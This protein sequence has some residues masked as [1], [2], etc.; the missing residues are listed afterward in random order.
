MSRQLLYSLA[1]LIGG[2]L[3]AAVLIML[4]PEPIEQERI[5]EVPLVEAVALK[6]TSGT[7]PVLGQGTVQARD[8][9]VIAAQVSGRLTYV[10]PSFREGGVL[11]KGAPLFRIEQSDF[12]NQVRAAEA[13][14]EAQNVAVLEAE[15]EVEIAREELERFAA[16]AQAAAAGGLSETVILPPRGMEDV[17][18]QTQTDAPTSGISAGS[19]GLATREPQ[20]QSTKAALD[21]AEANLSDAKLQLARTSVKAPFGGLVR[22]ENAAVGQ[23]VQPGEQLGSL[24]ATDAYEVRVSLTADE[25]ALIPGLLTGTGGRVPAEVTTTYGGTRYRWDAYVDRANAILDSATRNIEVF[26]RVPAPLT[27]GRILDE[28]AAG[29]APPLLLGAFVDV[30]ITGASLNSYATVPSDAVRPGNEIWVVR[31]GKLVV[32]EVRVIQRSDRIAYITSPELSK[33]GKLITSNLAAP[34]EGMALRVVG[35][36]PQSAQETVSVSEAE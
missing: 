22:E 21:R 4:R 17:A 16:R 27:S 35:A 30:T 6:E 3:I 34:I 12:V 24:V 36:E 26:V 2:T 28:E 7:I 31:D 10:N 23:L 5:E 19:R 33:G 25:A 29:R 13:D 32:L 15:E 18:A 9:V 14:V 8:E 1:F 11:A 20:L